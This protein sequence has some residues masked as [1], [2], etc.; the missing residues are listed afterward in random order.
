M[1][2]APTAEQFARALAAVTARSMLRLGD[3][4]ALELDT[5]SPI[6]R[7]DGISLCTNGATRLI[8]IF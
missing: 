8:K 2:Q 7:G 3:I 6:S 5:A 1:T 4:L